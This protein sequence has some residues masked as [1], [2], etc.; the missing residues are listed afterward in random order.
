MA[1]TIQSV[2]WTLEMGCSLRTG[3]AVNDPDK[4]AE[5]IST[6]RYYSDCLF[7]SRDEF[8]IYGDVCVSSYSGSGIPFPSGGFSI[9][10]AFRDQ[11][12]AAGLV[13]MC[14]ACPANVPGHHA[15]G[16]AGWLSPLLSKEVD[17]ILRATVAK[18]ALHERHARSF[19]ATSLLWYGL[20]TRSPLA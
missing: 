2:R 16:C 20:W 12:G 17:Q 4:A 9:S 5:A 8:G 1:D 11:G 13:A 14:G 18:H 3:A 6:A 15:A 10:D 19:P 7:R